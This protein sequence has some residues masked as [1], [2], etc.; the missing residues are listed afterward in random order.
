[1]DE[2]S[3]ISGLLSLRESDPPFFAALVALFALLAP[4]A[5]TLAL[6][7]GSK[8]ASRPARCFPSSP[9]T[10]R[11]AMADIFLIALYIVVARGV[12]GRPGGD[13]PGGLYLFTGAI[14]ASLAISWAEEGA[15]PVIDAK[16]HCFGNQTLGG[17]VA[18]L[19]G[20]TW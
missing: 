9:W 13:A 1:M 12:G 20:W 18:D 16:A 17:K 11:L 15:E 5:K 8:S 4:Y 19:P 14:L 10:G 6:A 2:I 7:R 3:V